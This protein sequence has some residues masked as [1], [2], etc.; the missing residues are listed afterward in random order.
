ML[1]ELND[2]L[3]KPISI[4]EIHVAIKRLKTN[5]ALGSD[6]LLNE[7]FI[8]SFDIISVHPVDLFNAFLAR[9]VFLMSGHVVS[10][11]R[12]IKR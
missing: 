1:M 6:Q 3:D 7:Y 11:F 2:E 4:E 10:L 9:V 8:V 5:K 12:C